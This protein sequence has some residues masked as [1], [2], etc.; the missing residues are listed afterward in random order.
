M[1]TATT[2]RMMPDEWGAQFRKYPVGHDRPGPRNPRLTPYAIPF[3]RAVAERKYRKVVMACGGQVAKT[4]TLLDVIGQRL[5]QSPAPGLY[6]GPNKQFL[7]EMFEPRLMALFDEAPVLAGKVARGKRM[8]KTR[9]VIGGV[10]FRLAHAGSST[11]LKS[12]PIAFAITDEADE[13]M[14]NVKGQGDPIGLIDVRGETIADFVHAIVSTPSVGTAEVEK[15][16][17]TGLEFWKYQDPKNVESTIWRL[18]QEGTRRHWAWRCP[19]CEE[20]FIPRMALLKF[21]EKASPVE[22]MRSA[23]IACPRCGGLI[24]DSQKAELNSRGVYVAPGQRITKDGTVEG[25]TPPV[26]IDSYWVS[27]LCSPFRTFGDRAAALATARKSGDPNEIQTVLSGRFGELTSPFAGGDMITV[28]AIKAKAQPY[29][30]GQIPN[31]VLRVFA[32]VDVQLRSVFYMVMG[33]GAR[34]TSWVLDWGQIPGATVEEKVWHDLASVLME[35][36]GDMVIERALVDS[37]FRPDK[38]EAGDVHRVYDFCRIYKPLVQPAKGWDSRQQPLMIRT[39]EIKPSGKRAPFSID[40]VHA[41]SDFFKSMVSMRVK[42]PVGQAGALYVPEDISPDVLEGIASE[43]RI[44]ENGKPRWVERHS[45][46]HYLDCAALCQAAGYMEN[47]QR[48]PEGV[49]RDGTIEASPVPKREDADGETETATV[50]LPVVAA[51]EM[52]LRERMAA[53]ARGVNR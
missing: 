47:V 41:N 10:P 50:K 33:F 36:I 6:V 14:A 4:E 18:F 51:K 45:H 46:N 40:L 48:I 38:P 9:K 37:G 11:A 16:P 23:H 12:D 8:T 20:W 26:L 5:D 39:I 28:D 49:T 21:D 34:G 25:Q 3:G 32:G 53:R 22:I 43:A 1:L 27:G 52:S 13:L 29:K 17:E 31:E 24:D 44:V 42:I 2:P 19:H 15:D 35:P 7:N 30:K